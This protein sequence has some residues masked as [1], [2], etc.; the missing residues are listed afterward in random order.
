M[1]PKKKKAVSP[2]P[3]VPAGM[4]FPEAQ[5]AFNREG[6]G[7]EVPKAENEVF[8]H[9]C[10]EWIAQ[11][12]DQNFSAAGAIKPFMF[13]FDTTRR[14]EDVFPEAQ[15]YQSFSRSF[16]SGVGGRIYSSTANLR[17]VYGVATTAG[18]CPELLSALSKAGLAAATAVAVSPEKRMALVHSNGDPNDAYPVPFEHLGT[19]DFD[20]TQ[21][22]AY[23]AE[24]FEAHLSTHDGLCDIWS[25]PSKRT[26]K[27]YAERQIQ[28]TLQAFFQYRVLRKKSAKIDREIQTHAGRKDLR[29]IR[30]KPDRTLEGAVMELKVLRPTISD[31]KNLEWAIDGVD[32]AARYTKTD[33]MT[34]Y[35]YVCCYDG[36]K[37]DAPMPTAVAYAK[38]KAVTWRRY[39]METP[40]YP[41]VVNGFDS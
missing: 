17:K 26:L 22:D 7:D 35:T 18:T 40:Q 5:S 2:E 36:R 30:V 9:E 20:F 13:V 28:K 34:A 3:F 32:Q 21:L 10:L 38:T 16:E 25:K 15:I 19:K 39:F 29:I 31:E 41:R 24:F 6:Y 8:V 33:D 4:T 14:V 1:T 11:W 27:Q 12:F 37:I 23:L